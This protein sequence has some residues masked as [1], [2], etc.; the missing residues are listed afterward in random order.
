MV[1]AYN[2][3]NAVAPKPWLGKFGADNNKSV[4]VIQYDLNGNFIAEHD[5]MKEAERTTGVHQS[6]ISRAC[7]TDTNYSSGYKWK[8]KT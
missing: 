8:Y 7:R 4:A 2:N 6:L 5:S 3:G 1:H